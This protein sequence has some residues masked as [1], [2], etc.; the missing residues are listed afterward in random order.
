MLT[1]HSPERNLAFEQSFSRIWGVRN[2]DGTY[3]FALVADDA[4]GQADRSSPGAVLHPVRRE[5]LHQVM[6][7]RVLWR[8][9]PGTEARLADNATITW[10]ILPDA[11]SESGE[12]LEYRGTAFVAVR[13]REDVAQ[14]AIRR[15]TI[16]LNGRRG[17]LHDPIGPASVSGEFT[18]INDSARL[19]QV[20]ADARARASGLAKR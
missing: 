13:P 2:D 6:D 5:P 4:A 8:P 7:I 18:A 16:S 15:G 17:A 14:V 1:I 11:P 12:V 20:L 9:M 19:T 3:E 10:Y